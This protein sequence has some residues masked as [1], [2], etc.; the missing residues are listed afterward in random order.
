MRLASGRRPAPDPEVEA[1]FAETSGAVRAAV[2]GVAAEQRRWFADLHG[3]LPGPRRDR[4]RRAGRPALLPLD[5]DQAHAHL[6]AAVDG[7]AEGRPALSSRLLVGRRRRRAL[8]AFL[9]ANA[10]VGV[11]RPVALAVAWI[12]VVTVLYA[13]TI[14][15]R[16]LL[17]RRSVASD[18]IDVVTDEEAR[19]VP[20][21]DL[22]MFSVLVPAYREPEVIQ[23]LLRA[24][25][26]LEYPRDKLEVK[27][28]LEADDDDTIA[29]ATAVEVGLAVDVVLVPPA[30]PRTK[31]KALNYGLQVCTGEVV[32]VYDAEDV[33]DP[34]QLRRAAV[35]L[36]RHGPD[37]ACVQAQLSFSNVHQNVI[38]RW[39]TLEYAVWFELFL[40]G[41]VASGAPVPLGGTSNHFRR[42]ALDE[43]LAWD[44][45]NVTEDADLGVRLHRT[46]RRTRVL[47]SVTHEEA[48]SDFVNWVK[49]RSRWYK[50]YLQTWIV[51]MRRPRSLRR[52]LGWKGFLRC[53]LFVGGTPLLAL[54]NPV[55]WTLTLVWFLGHPPVVKQLFPAAVFYPGLACWALGNFAIAYL[56]LVATRLTRRPD[57][58]WAALLVPVY[59]VM[60][61]V[62]AAKAALQLVLTPSYWEKTVHGLQDYGRRA[63]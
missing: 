14:V 10:A 47:R 8:A 58:L 9:V 20:E 2:D 63:A 24:V 22:P 52:E 38:T 12:A 16:L 3:R 32:T 5:P 34:L 15:D 29:L 18:A 46:G 41:L 57:L 54:V 7:L 13:A 26:R 56:W 51:H 28:L 53:N 35:V 37:V 30:E 48:N 61:S 60:M 19:A 43:L 27:L 36:A 1:W 11:L 55:F 23:H 25:G 31:P 50:G 45:Y 4:R 42:A 33:P 49:Q 39:F 62:A 59:W 40:P 6:A 17:A 44:P 21:S